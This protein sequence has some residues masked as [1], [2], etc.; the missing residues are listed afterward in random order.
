MALFEV[1]AMDAADERVL[2]ELEAL[3]GTLRHHV[4]EP[5]RWLGQ[6][7]RS[8]IAGAV[9]GSNTI[10]GH[11]VGQADAEA[12]VA[13]EEMLTEHDART[14]AAVAGYN[15]ALTYVLQAARFEV[16][17]YDP[18]LLSALH[19][20]MLRGELDRS[21][22]RYRLGPI[23]VSG[24]P[25]NPPVYT[26]PPA[27]DVPSLM[28]ELC[29]WLQD[30]DPDAPGYV[31]AAMAHLNLVS[32][33]PWRDGNGR[34][35]RCLH[36]LVL[37]RQLVLAPEFASIEEWLGS[38]PHNTAMYYAALGAA[39]GGR[40]QPER[41]AH[42][43]VRFCLRAHHLQAQV[44]QRRLDMAAE[45]WR[46]LAERVAMAGLGERT[47]AAVY[48]AAR[49]DGVRRTTYMRDEGLT[50]DQA[51]RD[52]Q[53]LRAAGLI[54]EAGHGRTQRYLAAGPAA[55]AERAARVAITS[56]PLRDP[57]GDA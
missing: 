21:P 50:R 7:R 15:D 38:S 42:D 17:G 31:R 14:R 8:M 51:I 40:F 52:L 36:T 33:H 47:I 43:W 18:M 48:A 20:M 3:R 29:G 23:W 32:V 56:Q 22:G 24:A 41:D 57:Y 26:G 45:V 11:T 55:Q 25:D 30:G 46:V 49:P 2:G 37:A 13:G 1:P 19:F 4:A 6:L 35:A 39:Q 16:F 53:A 12:I 27:E 54:E 44:V 28:V 5:R 34:M 9:R 10:E